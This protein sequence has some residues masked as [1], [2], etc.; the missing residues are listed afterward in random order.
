[1]NVEERQSE[2][3]RGLARVRQFST[4]LFVLVTLLYVMARWMEARQ[5]EAHWGILAAFAE[6][7]MVGALA[8]WFAVVA[9]FR[10]PLGVP[11]P[12]TAII[13]ENRGRIADNIGAFITGNF[14]RT[15]VIL[16][17]MAEL[18]EKEILSLGA[19]GRVREFQLRY[20]VRF[21]L[22]DDQNQERIPPSE[23]VLKR[24]YSFNDEQALSKESEEGLLYNDMRKD[25]VQQLVRR[26]QAVKPQ[27]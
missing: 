16:Q 27:S 18:Q 22:T 13:P 17:I 12:H 23:I 8:D 14:L 7:A 6:A 15:E 20:R 4:A 10:H 21:R 9:L 19:S 5:P 2:Q 24:D 1:M 11:L 25:A 26:L 3:Q